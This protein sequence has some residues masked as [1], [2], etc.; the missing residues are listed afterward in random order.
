MGSSL[1]I[2]CVPEIDVMISARA[3]SCLCSHVPLYEGAGGSRRGATPGGAQPFSTTARHPLAAD[4]A[5][6]SLA[7]RYG[8][9]PRQGLRGLC[10]AGY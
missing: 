4:G 1:L 6:A 3:L 9:P 7:P 2:C 8:Q 5:L 10:A